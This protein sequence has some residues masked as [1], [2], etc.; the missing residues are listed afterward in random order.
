MSHRHSTPPPS[1][2]APSLSPA[3]A[4]DEEG[5]GICATILTFV[6][7]VL[8]LVTMPLSL[9]VT[10][11]VSFRKCPKGKKRTARGRQLGRQADWQAG[12]LQHR[13]LFLSQVL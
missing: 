3:I 6:S 11:K 2:I 10:V 4:A 7:F 12:S 5:P 13:G 9:C 1:L 8:V